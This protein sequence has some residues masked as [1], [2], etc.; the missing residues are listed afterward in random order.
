M[1]R[2]ERD[3]TKIL[4]EIEALRAMHEKIGQSS[5][6]YPILSS[7]AETNAW[8]FTHQSLKPKYLVA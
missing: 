4:Q 7:Y 2:D 8:P 1:T 3:W 6:P 5:M